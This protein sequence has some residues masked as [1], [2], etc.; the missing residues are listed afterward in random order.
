MQ[1]VCNVWRN[2]YTPQDLTRDDDVTYATVYETSLSPTCQLLEVLY[3]LIL[4]EFENIRVIIII[5]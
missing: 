3:Y 1:H 4:F 2:H 5:S